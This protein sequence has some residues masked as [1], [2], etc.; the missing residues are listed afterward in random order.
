MT[1]TKRQSELNSLSSLNR[2][3][4]L[5]VLNKKYSKYSYEENSYDSYESFLE[6]VG[7]TEEA[8]EVTP[9]MLEAMTY[10]DDIICLE[11]EKING[12]DLNEHLKK[13]WKEK[14]KQTSADLLKKNYKKILTL[15]GAAT[16]FGMS[17]GTATP[18]AIAIGASSGLMAAAGFVRGQTGY[19]EYKKE[20]YDAVEK[21]VKEWTKK[22]N[23]YRSFDKID[24]LRYKGYTFDGTMDYRK[25]GMEFSSIYEKRYVFVMKKLWTYLTKKSLDFLTW[26]SGGNKKINRNLRKAESVFFKTFNGNMKDVSDNILRSVDRVYHEFMSKNIEE[27][28]FNLM[29]R[30]RY[31]DDQ[32]KENKEYIFYKKNMPSDEK[33]KCAI[34]IKDH[35][36]ELTESL[37]KLEA[38]ALIEPTDK[39]KKPENAIYYA[40]ASR[41]SAIF[42][43]AYES[44]N[45]I[46]S[47]RN[48]GRELNNQRKM[49]ALQ[50]IAM[51]VARLVEL[52]IESGGS[53]R[54]Y[55][56]VMASIFV[57]SSR[58]EAVDS[59]KEYWLFSEKT[60]SLKNLVDK[61]FDIMD[62]FNVNKEIEDR[63]A[64]IVKDVVKD[65]R[66][67]MFK[68]RKEKKK[69]MKSL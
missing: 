25:Y 6:S 1:T 61:Y 16:A 39:F 24:S 23:D 15:T 42:L 41:V 7:Y 17:G 19:K 18:L 40:G 56:E 3:Q 22:K 65:K 20:R 69:I 63:F 38:I 2:K 11:M 57:S 31:C 14:V 64:E 5:M 10:I 33:L 62:S 12:N 59:A 28:S 36:R 27:Y 51:D 21:M 32:I 9:E 44:D 37:S 55:Q 52:D 34:K 53:R 35:Q 50:S 66:R 45:V 67:D 30:V 26:H 4:L 8:P 49:A 46:L 47:E 60:D 58:K 54:N 29:E 48:L 13:F 68:T 43:E